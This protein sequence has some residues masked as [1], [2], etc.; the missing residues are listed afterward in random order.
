MGRSGAALFEER[1]ARLQVYVDDP[2]VLL[3]GPKKKAEHNARILL[4]WWLA[5][6][7]RISWKKAKFEQKAKWIVAG[8]DF[9]DN[10]NATVTIPSEFCEKVIADIDACLK[11]SAVPSTRLR[12]LA[13]TVGWAASI[14]AVVWSHDA[15][16]WAACADATSNVAMKRVRH[17]LLWQ[18]ALFQY[19]GPALINYFHLGV[20]WAL[21][22]A[23]IYIDASPWGYG[24]FLTWDSS[25][26]EYLAGGWT[27]GD[28]NR[29]D[30]KIGDAR[31]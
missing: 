18:K 21:P 2:A 23:H 10:A 20:K 11:H 8:I 15:P 27:E 9:T 31:G 29:F 4:W 12:K 16:L 13:G 19:G 30:L 28:L 26:I 3:A 1:E 14:S 22:R 7:V 6:G 25:P 24:A 17:A 5:L